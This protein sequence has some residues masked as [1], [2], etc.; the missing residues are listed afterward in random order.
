MKLE[1]QVCSLELAKKLKELGVKQESLFFWEYWNNQ[2]YAVKFKP[3]VIVPDLSIKKLEL[4]AAFTVAELG[5]L[6]PECILGEGD[7]MMWNYMEGDKRIFGIEYCGS[8]YPVFKSE[9][10]ADA[11]AQMLI[12]LLENKLI[13]L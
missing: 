8:S 10:E 5:Q 6:L 4:F 13:T 9:K 12:Y 7:L 1:H 3:F 11:R 2:V